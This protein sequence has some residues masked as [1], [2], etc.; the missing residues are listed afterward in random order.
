M[1][2]AVDFRRLPRVS[3][4]RVTERTFAAWINLNANDAD[5]KAI[6]APFADTGGVMLYVANTTLKFYSN[7]HNVLPGK[8]EATTTPLVLNTWMH[9][10][11][12]YNHTSTS[13]VP[14]L[15][16]N[17]IPQ[18]LTT[19]SSPAGTLNVELGTHVVIGNVKTVVIDYFWKF[20]GQIYDP[21]IYDRIITPAEAVTLYNAGTPDYS[22]VTDGLVLQGFAVRTEK[23]A[24]YVDVILEEGVT[25]FENI[26]KS[27]GFVVKHPTGRAAP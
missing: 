22:L 23:I 1:T 17:G 16:V 25:V 7:R 10:C 8:W 26:H 4:N 13:N 18:S 15:Y 21:R 27:V 2:R 20:K 5:I 6:I 9:V 14:A 11:A 3:A 24:D 12:T 19:V